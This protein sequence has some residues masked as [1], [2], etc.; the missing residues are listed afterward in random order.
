MI[1]ELSA[2]LFS[3]TAVI[4]VI[5]ISGFLMVLLTTSFAWERIHRKPIIAAWV[6]F[7]LFVCLGLFYL[8]YSYRKVVDTHVKIYQNIS[9][10]CVRFLQRQTEIDQPEPVERY[11]QYLRDCEKS[12]DVIFSLYL[13]RR[14]GLELP[15]GGEFLNLTTRNA[16]TG[17][18]EKAQTWQS[19]PVERLFGGASLPQPIIDAFKEKTAIGIIQ[20]NDYQEKRMIYTVP[21]FEQDGIITTVLCLEIREQDWKKE[22]LFARILPHLFFISFLFFFF[23][24]QIILIRR[25]VIVKHLHDH[26]INSFEQMLEHLISV[27][28]SAEEKSIDRNY[29]I[30]QVDSEFKKPLIPVLEL[31]FLL[32]RQ[33][34]NKSE[35]TT[36]Y[37]FCQEHLIMLEKMLWGHKCLQRVLTDIRTFIDFEWNRLD[38]QPEEFSPQHIIYDLRNICQLY[39]LEKPNIKFRVD[40]IAAIPDLVRG[41][42]MKIRRVLEELLEMSINRVT[43]GHIKITCYM[44]NSQL[45]WIILDTGKMPTEKEIRQLNDFYNS[46][47][48]RQTENYNKLMFEF[49][50]GS[51]IAA[52]FTHLLNGNISFQSTQG[53]GNKCTAIFPVEI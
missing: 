22:L 3:T 26:R 39:L 37:E 31:S 23:V 34:D 18:E 6:I 11:F 25:R 53:H 8:S 32:R 51:S 47:T 52:A 13:V 1:Q 28:M 38:I 20:R 29:L 46:G 42:Q 4:I 14:T 48:I 5:V 17:I 9:Q 35:T 50:F 27:K 45:C 2:N 40:T 49:D 19:I 10:H 7:L 12:N 24:M 43:D 33:L 15:F 36:D 44:S 21:L 30:R 41:D 16:D